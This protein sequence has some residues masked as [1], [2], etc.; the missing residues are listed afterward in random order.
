[1]T[2]LLLAALGG[3]CGA[4]A[5]WRVDLWVAFRWTAARGV[6]R[7]PLATLV[8]NVSGSFS[9]GLLVGWLGVADGAGWLLPL[10]ATGFLGAYTTFSTWMFEAVRLLQRGATRA[11][12]VYLTLTV[13]LGVGAAGLGVL[14]GA[15]LAGPGTWPVP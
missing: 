13:G 9:L 6:A 12:L 14:A 3:A 7:I 15:V 8:V 2:D 10:L 11:A 4:V 1:M 5:R